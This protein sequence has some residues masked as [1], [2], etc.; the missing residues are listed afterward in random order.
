M[1]EGSFGDMNLRDV[2]HIIPELYSGFLKGP[3]SLL[4]R[5]IVKIKSSRRLDC[6]PRLDSLGADL[7]EAWNASFFEQVFIC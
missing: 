3:T 2:L 7:Y 4:E 1:L 5:I 6:A